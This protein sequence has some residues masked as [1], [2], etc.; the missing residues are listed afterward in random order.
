MPALRAL[1]PAARATLAAT[2]PIKVPRGTTLF[3]GGDQA[4]SFLIVLRGRVAVS[5]TGPSG[6]EML[7]YEVAGGETCVQTTLALLGGQPYEGE[8]IVEEDAQAVAVPKPVF[9][10]LMVDSPAFRAFVFGSFGRRL[11]DVIHVLE[12]VAFVP[13]ESRLA[14]AL[15]ARAD[16]SGRVKATHQ[17]LASAIGSAREVVT[18]RL[19]GLRDRGAVRLDRGIVTVLERARLEEI[20]GQSDLV[21]DS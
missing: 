13:I 1:E 18:R 4:R 9:D 10:R 3:R 6:R 11:T 8:A 21:T 2:K 20:A 15:L 5:I 17:E 16:P 19:I 7:L 14:A 12:Q